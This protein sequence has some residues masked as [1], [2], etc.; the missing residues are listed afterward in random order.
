[1]LLI[2]DIL[3]CCAVHIGYM[4]II[5]INPKTRGTIIRPNDKGEKV[6]SLGSMKEFMLTP[7]KL[8]NQVARDLW[9]FKNWDINYP[10]VMFGS[11]VIYK[12]FGSLF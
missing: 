9:K 10:V 5:E 6:I 12:C 1:M 2:K 8:N 4:T 11:F 3:V 7:F